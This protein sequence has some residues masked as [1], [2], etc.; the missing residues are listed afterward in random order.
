LARAHQEGL[1]AVV[2]RMAQRNRPDV[3]IVRPAGEQGVPRPPRLG[4]A[5]GPAARLPSP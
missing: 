1:D 5:D 2:S 3:V 4:L